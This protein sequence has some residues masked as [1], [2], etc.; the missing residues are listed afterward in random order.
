[1]KTSPKIPISIALCTYNGERF[2]QEQLDSLAN[3][4]RLPDEVV[5]GDD[6][7][8]D[9]TM[10]I[11]EAW[12][13][14]VPFPVRIQRNERSFGPAK[15]F[16]AA[17]LRSSGEII[18]LCDQDD[19]WEPEKIREM[20]SVFEK[21]SEVGLV[22][23]HAATIGENGEPLGISRAE[24]SRAQMICSG[25]PLISP[26]CRK[27][28][29]PPGCCSAFRTELVKQILPLPSSM[30]HDTFFFLHLPALGKTVTLRKNLIR[31]RFHGHNVSF[32]GNWHR[33]FLE[34]REREKTSY[35]WLPGIHFH[36]EKRIQEFLDWLQTQPKSKYRDFHIRYIRGNQVHYPNRSRIQRNAII[37][38]PLWLI[39]IISGRYFERLQ[40][41]KSIAYDLG[42]GLANALNPLKFIR[43]CRLLFKKIGEKI[44]RKTK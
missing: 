34:H 1:M 22:F 43:E 18:F 8:T 33:Q 3:Q 17:I 7:S 44:T 26:F 21:D 5:V 4:T 11:L 16:E 41:V 15:N 37:F 20:T 35:Q 13:K 38:F 40:P 27:H 19:V 2:L 23:C 10:E 24:I 14:T 42:L 31:Y 29:N 12:A 25:W 9:K 32:Q 30:P 36:W 6:G 28:D 39:E